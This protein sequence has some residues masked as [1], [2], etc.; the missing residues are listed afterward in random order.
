M[1]PNTRRSRNPE[2]DACSGMRVSLLRA[3]LLSLVLGLLAVLT[4]PVPAVAQNQQAKERCMAPFK[5]KVRACVRQQMAA[6]GGQ[7]SQY[8]AECR[9]PYL[10]KVRECMASQAGGAGRRGAGSSCTFEAC[11]AHCQRIGGPGG[12]SSLTT[13]HCSNRCYRR[14]GGR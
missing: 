8:T 10:P 3:V 6:R 9:A 14:C 2:V 11:Y 1:A 7:P 12:G 4:Q 13:R 5:P